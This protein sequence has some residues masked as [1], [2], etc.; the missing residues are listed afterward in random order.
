MGVRLHNVDV[1][2][3]APNRAY[4]AMLDGGIVILDTTNKFR[5][6]PVTIFKYRGPGFTHTVYPVF[7]RN[8][9]EVSEEAFGPPPCSDGPKRATIWSIE[10]ER[11]PVLLSAAPFLDTTR[12]CPPTNSA[13][14]T[15][16][17]GSH[18]IWEGK[19]F[20]PSWSSTTLMLDSWFRGGIRAFDFT[21]PFNVR[22]VGHYIPAFNPATNTTGSIQINDVYVDDRAFVYIVDR[23]GDGLYILSSPLIRCG[24]G[25]C[26][27]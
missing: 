19:P 23:F 8:L 15:G 6:V 7:G 14:N 21:N 12:F 2:P 27:T 22:D 1:F 20:G 16:R 17:Y 4:L 25:Q 13:N 5:P 10:N 11:L 26:H 18:N 9:L 24:P 3:Q